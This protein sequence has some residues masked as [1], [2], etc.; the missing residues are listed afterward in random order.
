MDDWAHPCSMLISSLIWTCVFFLWRK[1][2]S[3]HSLGLWW[4][5]QFFFLNSQWCLERW[6]EVSSSEDYSR[7]DRRKK[8][9]GAMSFQS[10]FPLW[11][12]ELCSRVAAAYGPNK[13][14]G[15]VQA[16]PAWLSWSHVHGQV[17]F[18]NSGPKATVSGHA[19]SEGRGWAMKT[20]T[21]EGSLG[22]L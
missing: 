21:R 18:G 14:V 8:A 16:F 7:D 17:G 13:G 6:R 1:L 4:G 5:F 2:K 9:V 11:C 10:V 22:M 12:P 15:F 20:M 3:T 19:A